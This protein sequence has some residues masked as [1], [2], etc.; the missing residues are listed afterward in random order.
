MENLN[1]RKDMPNS[2]QSWP[3]K[4]QAS[5]SPP[6]STQKGQSDAALGKINED[7][8]Q[9]LRTLRMLE[10]RYSTLRKKMQM[11]DQNIIDDT[12]RIFTSLKLVVKD[13]DSLKM[14]VED[15]RLKLNMFA[16]EIKEMAPRQDLKILERYLDMWEPMQF[17]TEKQAIQ[18]IKDALKEKD[19]SEKKK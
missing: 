9:A 10:E 15:M 2:F 16:G 14:K 3:A 5:Q 17:L 4:N 8:G 6:L 1:Q 11:S 19:M 7:L 18:M 13:I 12:N